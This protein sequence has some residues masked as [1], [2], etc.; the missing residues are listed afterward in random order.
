[1]GITNS[2]AVYELFNKKI[3]YSKNIDELV[4][5]S[6][7]FN[8]NND[9]FSIIKELMIEVRDNH[10]YINRINFIID[11]LKLSNVKYNK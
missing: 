5:K 8:K 2:E 3:I 10:T 1:M 9:R 11:F 4:Q 7:E 6:L